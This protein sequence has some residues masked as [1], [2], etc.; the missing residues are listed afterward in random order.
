MVVYEV[1]HLEH[2]GQG[3]L[4]VALEGVDPPG[5]DGTVDNAVVR[6]EGDLHDL[7]GLEAMLLFGCRHQ[8]CLRRADSE[9]TRLGRV[10]DGGEVVDAVHSEVG[11]G[12]G[13]ALVF[14]G[15]ELA[16][17][18]LLGQGLG[19]RR[20]GGQTLV[21][22]ALDDGGDQAGGSGD[23]DRDVRVLVAEGG[24]KQTRRR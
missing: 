23:S 9:D 8:P 4:E 24:D 10:D 12:E 6:A 11:D 7:H 2:E 13:S 1:K 5:A 16:I 21:V 22:R 18:G 15:S 3:V 14:G 17:T 19:F 20:D